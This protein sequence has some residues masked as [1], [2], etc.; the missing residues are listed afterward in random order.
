MKNLP[1]SLPGTTR[2]AILIAVLILPLVFVSGA[3]SS[4]L[5]MKSDVETPSDTETPETPEIEA[6]PDPNETLPP[7]TPVFE[8]T[9]PA[10]EPLSLAESI[11]QLS[12]G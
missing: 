5:T 12:N 10:P 6:I 4:E 3:L 2:F 1:K 8:T 7:A 11:G 9:L